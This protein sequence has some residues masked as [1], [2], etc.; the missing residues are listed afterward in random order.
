MSGKE[1]SIREAGCFI[2]DIQ[3]LKFSSKFREQMNEL[4]EKGYSP[5]RATVRHIVFWQD[6]DKEEE[7]KII[8]PDVEFVKN[9]KI[10]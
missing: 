5:A 4:K 6:K 2:N 3:V 10:Q 8:L 9:E 7:I 1:L